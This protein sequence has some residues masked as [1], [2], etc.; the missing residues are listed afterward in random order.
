M[1]A[2]PADRPGSFAVEHAGRCV[3]WVGLERREPSRPGRA[4]TEGGDLEVSYLVLPSVWG[5]GIGTEAVRAV[6]AWADVHLG[7]AVVL[8]TQSSNAASVAL[9]R[10]LGFSEVER[11]EEFGAEQWFGARPGTRLNPPTPSAATPPT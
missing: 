4:L 9:A 3:G 7:E 8:C 11:F 1:A 2:I 5:R 6:L 10:R